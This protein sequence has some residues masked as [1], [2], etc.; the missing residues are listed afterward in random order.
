[1]FYPVVVKIPMAMRTVKTI[2]STGILICILAACSGGSGG[3]E[4]TSK[5][6]KGNTTTDSLVNGNVATQPQFAAGAKLIS[7]YD[8][9]TCHTVERKIYGPSFR[10]VAQRYKNDQSKAEYVGTWII[11]GSKGGQYGNLAMTP[12]PMV[13]REEATEMARYILSLK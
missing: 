11:N 10:E 7:R 2:F 13:S 5:Q 8:C 1:L 12:H 6:E 9:M 3:R 4:A